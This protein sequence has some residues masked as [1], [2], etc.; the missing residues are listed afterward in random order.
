MK[1]TTFLALCLTALVSL[2]ASAKIWR[3]NN[4]PTIPADF[5]TIQ[6]A[7]DG[8]MA[9]DTLHIEPSGIPYGDLTITKKLII[10]GNGFFL[11]ENTNNQVNFNSSIVGLIYMRNGCSGSKFMGLTINGYV[12]FAQSINDPIIAIIADNITFEKNYFTSQNY[13]FKFSGVTGSLFVNLN[14]LVIRNNYLKG[15]IQNFLISN[16]NFYNLNNIQILNNYIRGGIDLSNRTNTGYTNCYAYATIANNVIE[17]NIISCGSIIKNNIFTM[18][19]NPSVSGNTTDGNSITNNISA[20]PTGLPAGNGNQNGVAITTIFKG[21]TGNT[22]DSQWQLK[23]GSP[24]I[25]AG[26]SGEDCGMFGGTN[27]Y[28]LSGLPATPSVYGLSAPVNSSGNTLP[29]V[30]STKS[31]N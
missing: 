12:D 29:V 9:N 6:A 1:K 5:T 22:T 8:A 18:V 17:G 20:S 23:V 19:A 13:N 24:A 14:N 21:L 11:S 25:A 16:G 28:K 4:N 2:T 27:P 31:N 30:I 26:Q 10:I 15:T 7:H 3:V